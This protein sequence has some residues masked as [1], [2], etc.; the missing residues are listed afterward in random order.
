[1]TDP[2]DAVA[3]MRRR[4]TEI[5]EE[6]ASLTWEEKAR[7]TRDLLEGMPV[8]ERLKRRA[9]QPGLPVALLK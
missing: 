7:K 3:W 9:V 8:W 5:D 6:D 2:F 4:R 1:M